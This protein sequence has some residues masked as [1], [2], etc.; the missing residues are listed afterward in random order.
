MVV[1]RAVGHALDLLLDVALEAKLLGLLDHLLID[2]VDALV[3]QVRLGWMDVDLEAH[4]ASGLLGVVLEEVAANGD[5]EVAV[6]HVD[7][8][9]AL[10]QP[11]ARPSSGRR[12]WTVL[13]SHALHGPKGGVSRL[14][15]LLILRFRHVDTSVGC[16]S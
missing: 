14:L 9:E 1:R 16:R 2:P 3:L 10:A 4:P 5:G 11:N 15:P 7:T 8:D 12:F 13:P 6:R